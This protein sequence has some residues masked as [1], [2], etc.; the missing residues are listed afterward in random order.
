M[1]V[2]KFAPMGSALC[3]PIQTL[4]FSCVIEVAA[5]R[6]RAATSFHNDVWRV[7][8]DD[9]IVPD[10]LFRDVAE[11]LS[12]LGFV[13]NRAKSFAFPARFRESCGGEGYDGI[14]VSP[15]KIP[16]GFMS[17]GKL[18]SHHAAQ[19]GCRVDFANA[20]EQH[21]MG[22]L[23][24][25]LIKQ[26]LNNTVAPPLF[27]K[28]GHGAVYSPQPDNYRARSVYN[29]GYRSQP[30]VPAVQNLEVLVA[31]P[32]SAFRKNLDDLE[33]ARYFD[34]LRRM[35]YPPSHG[36]RACDDMFDPSHL[37]QVPSGPS[38][39]RLRKRWVVIHP[40]WSTR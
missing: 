14:N 40:T 2:E 25:W 21:D 3:F 16:K 13:L 18:T 15:L 39:D 31:M 30:D 4:I 34:T 33:E 27:S 22:L 12:E 17:V 1:V 36:G 10:V 28:E 6:A 11:M 35:T 26:L 37:L 19:Y 23:R 32:H 38:R 29:R 5:R 8:G 7:F 24:L 20:C 9:I